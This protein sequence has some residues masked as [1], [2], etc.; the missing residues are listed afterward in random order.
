MSASNGHRDL[1]TA[2]VGFSEESS[3]YCKGINDDVAREYA[4]Q[5]ARMI[6]QRLQG[7]DADPPRV[8]HQLFAPSRRL[9]CTALE[10]MRD[11]YFPVKPGGDDR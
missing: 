9:I 4:T 6:E 10:E 8:R 1:D 3:S 5:Y 7:M 11:K 2:L